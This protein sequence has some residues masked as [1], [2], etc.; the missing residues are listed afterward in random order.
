MQWEFINPATV[1]WDHWVFFL[2]QV[3]SMVFLIIFVWKIW[4]MA[5]ATRAAAESC[6]EAAI[7]AKEARLEALAPRLM[8]Y[9]SPEQIQLA[10]IVL[11]NI[12]TGT[13][14]DVRITFEPPLQVSGDCFDANLFFETV[15]PI[16]PPRY[17]MFHVIDT[18]SSYISANLP[19]RY[20][21]RLTYTGKEN[22]REYD[23]LHA[24]DID[25]LA[26]RVKFGKKDIDDLIKGVEKIANVLDDK[27][28][29]IDSPFELSYAPDL[30]PVEEHP[31]SYHISEIQ[32]GWMAA[33]SNNTNQ[34]S[35]LTWESTLRT[36][37]GLSLNAIIAAAKESAPE[38]FREAI[39]KVL[40]LLYVPAY[41]RQENYEQELDHAIQELSVNPRT[42]DCTGMQKTSESEP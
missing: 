39:L 16:I 42:T 11:E 23:E 25:S 38:N 17:R 41:L 7:E 6:A 1:Y 13:A 22:G 10:E 3:A 14:S 34:Q 29:K 4:E 8:V 28:K 37:R 24:L 15:K 32:A 18:W 2:V 5:A 31:L 9:F 27:L 36:L 19:K 20:D 30:H 12:G 40:I 26:H 35:G 21:V 33:K